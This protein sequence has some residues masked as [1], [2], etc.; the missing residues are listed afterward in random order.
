MNIKITDY[1]SKEEIQEAILEEIKD[2]TRKQYL[3]NAENFVS[4]I[5]YKALEEI[6]SEIIPDFK[7]ELKSYCQLSGIE[8]LVI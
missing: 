6:C 5:A 3:R 4:N 1:L 8:P 2:E 7:K